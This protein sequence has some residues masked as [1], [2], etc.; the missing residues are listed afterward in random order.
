VLHE[1]T[2]HVEVS[3]HVTRLKYTVKKIVLPY[4]P[5]K[6]QV[7]DVFTKAQTISQFRYFLSKLSV[8]YPT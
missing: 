2:K 3:C 8:F 6:E 7:V 1:R 4:I 5:S